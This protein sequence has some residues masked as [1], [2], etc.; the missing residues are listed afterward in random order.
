MS[1]GGVNSKSEKS[2]LLSKVHKQGQYTFWAYD[3]KDVRKKKS[4]LK[5]SGIDGKIHR[6]VGSRKR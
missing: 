1:K 3:C 6:V 4:A 2:Q 5:L